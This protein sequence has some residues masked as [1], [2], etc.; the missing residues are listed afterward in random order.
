ML[1]GS[2]PKEKEKESNPWLLLCLLPKSY[3]CFLWALQE[4][5]WKGRLGNALSWPWKCGTGS[6]DGK[7]VR[8]MASAASLLDV[9]HVNTTFLD[10][11]TPQISTAELLIQTYSARCGTF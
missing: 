3:Q 11:G 4:A 6:P 9:S 2:Q 1:L 7:I 10:N 5:S 8:L